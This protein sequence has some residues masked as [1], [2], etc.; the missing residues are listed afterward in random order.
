MSCSEMPTHSREC[1]LFVCVCVCV[2]SVECV[3]FLDKVKRFDAGLQIHS[4][5]RLKDYL[6]DGDFL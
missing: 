1:A 6:R 3:D 5:A 4:E 2:W